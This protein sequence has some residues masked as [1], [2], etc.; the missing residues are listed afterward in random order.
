MKMIKEFLIGSTWVGTGSMSYIMAQVG[1]AEVTALTGL[2]KGGSFVCFAAIS[3]YM[4]FYHIPHLHKLAREERKEATIAREA[5]EDKISKVMES[6][7]KAFMEALS[8]QAIILK[9]NTDRCNKKHDEHIK[10]MGEVTT[11]ITRHTDKP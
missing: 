2:V 3:L 4:I 1:P 11:A 5:R 7:D 8:S 10:A 6:K 9:E